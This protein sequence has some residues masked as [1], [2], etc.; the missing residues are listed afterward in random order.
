[1]FYTQ[2]DPIAYA[3]LTVIVGGLILSVVLGSVRGVILSFSAFLGFI[4]LRIVRAD[5]SVEGLLVALYATLLFGFI[6]LI[7]VV[8]AGYAA[9]MGRNLRNKQKQ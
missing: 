1:V 8:P 6:A 3:A 9:Q 5:R 2:P 4:F 7:V